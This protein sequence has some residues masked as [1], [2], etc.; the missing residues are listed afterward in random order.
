MLLSVLNDVNDD[1]LHP[2]SNTTNQVL[3]LWFQHFPTQNV[4]Y[5]M[6]EREVFIFSKNYFPGTGH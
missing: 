2:T 1:A 6:S 3:N 4:F 5:H